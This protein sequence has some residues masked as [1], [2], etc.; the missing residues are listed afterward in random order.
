MKHYL[1]FLDA[2]NKE[3]LDG[4]LPRTFVK[5]STIKRA[6]DDDICFVCGRK[7]SGKSAI[8]YMLDKL[9]DK[10]GGKIFKCSNGLTEEDYQVLHTS[11]IDEL[12]NFSKDEDS[13][14]QN[15]ETCFYEM[16]SLAIDLLAM[17]AIIKADPSAECSEKINNYM[18]EIKC[19]YDPVIFITEKAVSTLRNLKTNNET[20]L[21]QFVIDFQKIRAETKHKEALIIAT[22]A[23]SLIKIALFIDTMEQYDIS[24]HKIYPLRGLCLAVKNFLIKKR[25]PNIHIKCCLP[26]EITDE[27]FQKNLAKFLEFSVYLHWSYSELLELLAR[28]YCLFLTKMFPTEYSSLINEICQVVEES[29]R[30]Y[31]GS[32]NQ[33]WFSRFWKKIAIEKINNKFGSPENSCAYLIRHTQ[34]RPR[35][36]LSCMNFIIEHSL[37]NNNSPILSERDIIDGI[38]DQDN[39][40]QLLT[41]NLAIFSVPR[42][43]KNIT[44]LAA[45]ILTDESIIFEGRSFSRFA[46]RAISMLSRN[47]DLHNKSS[48]A[49]NLLIRSGLVGRV[50]KFD[51][52]NPSHEWKDDKTGKTCKFYVTEFEYSV[53]GKVIINEDSLCAVHPMLGDRLKLR[54][55]S[56]DDIGV[57]YPIPEKDDLIA[58]LVHVYATKGC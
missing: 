46:K 5:T 31:D 19:I 38:H 25:I 54:S 26:A 52:I 12:Y 58:E 17:Q 47:T 51:S 4:F 42:M 27:L 55:K 50:I 40:W 43:D 35:E 3:E 33:F 28:R 56:D 20:S 30:K 13:T 8:V 48:Y 37:K 21:T 11:F 2:T 18:E 32:K 7:G 49:K 29:E 15:I 1:G 57:V 23:M 39:L 41:D 9:T 53:P 16:W 10:G 6:L 34:K 24:N 22:K 14:G 36:I 44:E 45:T